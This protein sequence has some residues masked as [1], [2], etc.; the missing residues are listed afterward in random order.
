MKT[1]LKNHKKFKGCI[2]ILPIMYY[3][4]CLTLL[5]SSVIGTT[6]EKFPV[7]QPVADE[8]PPTTT[9]PTAA[10]T[11]VPTPGLL[12]P[13][14]APTAAHTVLLVHYFRVGYPNL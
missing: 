5:L 14:A 3:R 7:A 1:P 2:F 11:T 10:P 12:E 6:I 9:A 13:I 8:A 4:P